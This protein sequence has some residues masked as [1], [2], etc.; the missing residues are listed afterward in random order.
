MGNKVTDSASVRVEVLAVHPVSAGGTVAL[1]D[2][3]ILVDG[4]ELIIHNLKISRLPDRRLGVEAPTTRDHSGRWA[5]AISL[6]DDLARPV[7]SA[8][9][10]AYGVTALVV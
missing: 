7:A 10:D 1:V 3:S 6:P 9:L 2:V 8:V 5:P 4:V